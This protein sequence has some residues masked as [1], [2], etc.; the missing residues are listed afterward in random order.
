MARVALVCK[1]LTPGDAVGNDVL[2][3]GRALRACGHEVGLFADHIA[4]DRSHAW[5]LSR[6]RTFLAGRDGLVIYHHAIGWDRAVR[7]LGKLRCRRVVRYHNVTPARFFEGLNA[8]CVADCRQG[9]AQLRQLADYRCDLYLSASAFNQRELEAEGADS[10]RC[11]VLPPFHC[12]DRLN[13]LEADR[14]LLDACGDGRVNILFVG[15]LAPNK[16][17]AALLD[18]FAAYRGLYNPRCRLLLV[19]KEDSRLAPYTNS[20][21]RQANRLG[22]GSSVVFT[23]AVPDAALKA[24]YQASQAF[25]CASEHEGFCVPL[26]EA[27]AMRLPVIACGAAAVPDTVADA[28]LVWEEPDSWLLAASVDSVVRNRTVRESLGERGW[29]RYQE[30]FNPARLERQF[31]DALA[32]LT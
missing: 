21:R 29:R 11:R 32:G 9:R 16:G 5:P 15:R 31:L 28:G 13:S 6:L 10:G 22:L 30:H 2:G 18:A 23:G 14:D 27:M 25:L 12:I 8:G 24:F 3:M 19:G 1:S 26:V 17:H 4:L 7:L 20:L